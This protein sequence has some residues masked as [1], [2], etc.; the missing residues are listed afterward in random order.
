MASLRKIRSIQTPY[1]HLDVWETENGYDFEVAG[2]THATWDRNR[3]MTHY[4]WDAITAAVM[5]HPSSKPKRMLLLGLGGGTIVRQLNTLAPEIDITAIEIDEEMIALATE[6]MQ[7]HELNVSAILGDGYDFAATTPNRYDIIVDDIYIG[8]S[9][10]VDRPAL[11]TQEKIKQITQCLAPNGLF[12]TNMITGGRHQSSLTSAKKAMK[13]Y[14]PRTAYTRAAKG[15][16]V[17]LVGGDIRPPEHLQTITH[18][19]T[20]PDDIKAWE[21]IILKP[22]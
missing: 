3:L 19:L 20:H 5:L 15:F 2:G 1:N 16:N 22:F 10:G 12:I 13:A 18:K 11:I 8:L 4:A 14:F 9:R 21:K 17:A 6:F 7:L